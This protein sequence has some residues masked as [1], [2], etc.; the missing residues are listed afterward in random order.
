GVERLREAR[1]QAPAQLGRGLRNGRLGNRARGGGNPRRLQEITTLHG[2]SSEGK[3]TAP[4][5][6]YNADCGGESKTDKQTCRLFF[7]QMDG[8]PPAIRRMISRDPS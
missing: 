3:W 8:H 7:S 6:Q 2:G 1:R 4:M 5:G